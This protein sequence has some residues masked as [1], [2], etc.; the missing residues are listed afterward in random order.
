MA[1]WSD[2]DGNAMAL[3]LLTV[4]ALLAFWLLMRPGRREQLI[5]LAAVNGHRSF[6]NCGR[7]KFPMLAVSGGSVIS[8]IPDRDFLSSVVGL[9]VL[10]AAD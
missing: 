10:L 8:R 1:G 5:W 4:W 7:L 9:G 6:R 3:L 2:A